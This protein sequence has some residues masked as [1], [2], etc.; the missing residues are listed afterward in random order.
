MGKQKYD[1]TT[2]SKRNAIQKDL[3]YKLKL[4]KS[5]WSK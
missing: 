3:I 5:K 1:I 2:K 4:T